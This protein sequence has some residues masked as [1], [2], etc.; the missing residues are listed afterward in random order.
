[1]SKGRVNRM[2]KYF[3]FIGVILLPGILFAQEISER[4]EIMDQL[5]LT[6]QL[7]A[8]TEKNREKTVNELQLLNQQISLREQL[9]DILNA[10]IILQTEEIEELNEI[11]CQMEED[12]KQIMDTYAKT[13]RL[14]YKS[15]DRDNFFLSI[16]TSG[17]ISE[18]YYRAQYFQ[19]FSRYRQQQI[20]MIKQTQKFLANKSTDLQESIVENE[21][22]LDEKY[23]EIARLHMAKGKH[24]NYYA[25]VRPREKNYRKSV[26]QQQATVKTQIRKTETKGNIQQTSYVAEDATG[27]AELDYAKSF[28]KN[29]GAL[30]WPVPAEK[31]IVIGKFGKT[32]DPFGNKIQNEGIY[33]RTPKGQKVITVYTGIVTGVKQLPMNG[34]VM[35]IIEHGQYRTV[36]ANLEES[37]VTEGQKV[38]ASDE[39]GI[40]KTDKRSGETI[41][42]FLIYK[43]PDTFMDP[44]RWMIRP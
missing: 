18:A 13:A 4:Q 5:R 22:L 23:L 33:I 14:T 15:F 37:F 8:E 11:I 32:E 30:A 24:T 29:K 19:Q 9:I 42:N 7:L 43:E 26:S 40:V 17:S 1:M 21:R 35:V 31:G 36:Y 20:R 39:I 28:V 41:L 44:E 34:G 25:A 3:L 2:G 16:L 38:S 27:A 12:A 10:E 6:D